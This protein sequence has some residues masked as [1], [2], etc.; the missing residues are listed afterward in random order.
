[1]PYIQ[2]DGQNLY[3]QVEGTGIPIIFIHPFLITQEVFDHQRELADRYQLIRLDVR[4]HGKSRDFQGDLDYSLVVSDV[5]QLMDH[6]GIQQAYICGYSTASSIA[7]F[8][9]MT[10][11]QR[12]LGGVLVSGMSEIKTL[13]VKGLI[14]LA[15]ML[16]NPL[17]KKLLALSIASGNANDFKT[18]KKLYTHSLQSN[19]DHV[20]VFL[21]SGLKFNCTDHLPN[22][23]QPVLLVYGKSD[24][25][26]RK[27]AH[28]LHQ[29]I[30]KSTLYFLNGTPHQI[31]TKNHLLLNE[32]IRNWIH[33]QQYRLSSQP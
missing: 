29:K 7:L 1:M 2:I 23:Q 19:I 33:D 27:N 10:H 22:I 21:D 8:A 9:L 13:R 31:P 11:P 12:F 30:P 15:K 28:L 16:S 6:L 32:L 4:G 18:F 24:S 26:F 5:I 17:T 3:Y 20:K 14:W 25:R